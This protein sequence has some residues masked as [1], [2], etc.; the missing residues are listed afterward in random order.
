MSQSKIESLLNVLQRGTKKILIK[1]KEDNEKIQYSFVAEVSIFSEDEIE[2][3]KKKLLEA[4]EEL[5]KPI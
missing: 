1:P 5:N 4:I 3:I 2:G